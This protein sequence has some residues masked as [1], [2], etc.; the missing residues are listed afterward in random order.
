MSHRIEQPP[1][2]S[3]MG[4]VAGDTG[5]GPRPDAVVPV[6]ELP[7]PGPV[8]PGAEDT[9]FAPEQAADRG[10]MGSMALAAVPDRRLVG[11]ALAP[12]ACHLPVTS[13]AEERLPLPEHGIVG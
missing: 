4:V 8:T 11:H 5:I 13:Q 3:A 6:Q 12:E 1:V 9:R 7:A 10:T 2:R